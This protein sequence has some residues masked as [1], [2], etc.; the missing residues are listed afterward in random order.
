MDDTDGLGSV[1]PLEEVQAPG[2][3]EDQAAFVISDSRITFLT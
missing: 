1:L 3:I 2:S